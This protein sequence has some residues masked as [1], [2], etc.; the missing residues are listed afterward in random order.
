MAYHSGT[1]HP[2]HVHR[3]RADKGH[4]A[5]TAVTLGTQ[6]LL[7]LV[8]GEEPHHGIEEISLAPDGAD[9]ADGDATSAQY[10]SSASLSKDAIGFKINSVQT[11]AAAVVNDTDLYCFWAQSGKQDTVYCTRRCAGDPMWGKAIQV[12]DVDGKPLAP[13]EFTATELWNGHIVICHRPAL[14]SGQNMGFYWAVYDPEEVDEARQQ[15]C[16]CKVVY[17]DL[18]DSDS[19]Q[20][21][22]YYP[23]IESLDPQGFEGYTIRHNP[24]LAWFSQGKE[25][26]YLVT[27][28]VSEDTGN[29]YVFAT[30]LQADPSKWPRLLLRWSTGRLWHW[31]DCT[32]PITLVRDP[33]GRLRMFTAGVDRKTISR[34]LDTL[35]DVRK[36]A[37]ADAWS[38]PSSAGG[39]ADESNGGISA[40][41]IFGPETSAASIPGAP[42]QAPPRAES[43]QSDTER[44]VYE[45]VLYRHHG[46]KCQIDAYGK[47]R[48]LTNLTPPAE[49]GKS[50]NL[51]ELVQK[52]VEDKK[53][54]KPIYV[55]HGIIDGPIPLPGEN[56]KHSEESFGNDFSFGDLVYGEAQEKETTNS[57]TISYEFGEKASYTTT[58]GT[59]P[60]VQESFAA[61]PGSHRGDANATYL[62]DRIMQSATLANA[63]ERTLD[64]HGTLFVSGVVFVSTAY[65][66]LGLD[67][68]PVDNAPVFVTINAIPFQPMVK[69]FVPYTVTAGDLESYTRESWN[70]KMGKGYFEKTVEA[71]AYQFT[72]DKKFLAA[73]A[74]GNSV[75]A[76]KF[77]DMHSEATSTSWTLDASLYQ[78]IGGGFSVSVNAFVLSA[79]VGGFTM[80]EMS[81]FTTH[82]VRS[83]GSVDKTTW[84]IQIQN[85]SIPGPSQPGDTSAYSWRIYFLPGDTRWTEEL[86]KHVNHDAMDFTIDKNSAP[87]RI[88]FE[89]DRIEKCK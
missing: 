22:A 37:G 45:V 54:P 64:P 36:A 7:F 4:R 31:K 27:S 47:L 21:P 25:D 51:Y 29:A 5:G 12:L 19:Y 24:R 44:S 70:K 81:G 59:G 11:V 87:W 15:W 40:G 26:F 18:G 14:S 67:G 61:G 8:N 39:T 10:W 86:L 35:H 46:V 78:G 83:K 88:V 84:G 62:G 66:F 89:V 50:S 13:L 76:P 1:F 60:D 56:I 6:K 75:F 33:A 23:G 3:F 74:D 20:A 16:P 82:Q 73:S 49:S 71:N 63:K 69:P 65:Q 79:N 41:Y 52:A 32:M 28:F 9:I 80:S 53:I 42:K 2:P 30:N 85:Y 38:D 34:T 17:Q 68:K 58:Q 55:L 72:S 43:G 57:T 77:V 48:V